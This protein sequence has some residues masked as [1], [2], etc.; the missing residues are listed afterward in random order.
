MTCKIIA[1][2]SS[3][4]AVLVNGV[5]LDCGVPFKKLE[6]YY[7]GFQLVLLTHIH[8]DHFNESTV[9]KLAE[10]R[11]TL[12][13][14]AGEWMLN[15]L[16]RAGVPDSRIDIYNMEQVY[17]YG[18]G[19]SVEAFPLLHDVQNCG[20][21]LNL[22]GEKVFYATDTGSLDGISAKGFNLYLIE[23]NYRTEELHARQKEK[24]ESGEFSYE[25]RAEAGHLSREQADAFLMENAI[26]SSQFAYLHEH[27]G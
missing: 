16:H 3:G 8:G 21:K 15:R 12:R 14:G 4:N 20:Y 17:T 22:N 10:L 19:F 13:F 11:P 27:K 2:G 26:S 25:N 5:L 24:L 18:N 6:P 23:A 7:R 1:T 9:R